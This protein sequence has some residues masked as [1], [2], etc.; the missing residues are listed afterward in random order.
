VEALQPLAR[1][2][3]A[4]HTGTDAAAFL[5]SAPRARRC[6]TYSRPSKVSAQPRSHTTQEHV[7]A[8]SQTSP[9]EKANALLTNCR[10]S[11][12]AISPAAQPQQVLNTTQGADL[13]QSA[14]HET[15]GTQ[16]P[17]EK[18][19]QATHCERHLQPTKLTT[20]LVP[21]RGVAGGT[22]AC[23]FAGRGPFRGFPEDCA[24]RHWF[25]KAAAPWR[26]RTMRR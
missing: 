14:H 19:D 23:R 5:R 7:T 10:G 2:S 12:P 16:L 26:I 25:C 6:R 11:W 17:P 15:Q 1:L 18:S 3:P 8:T 13:P 24:L 22:K 20:S 21:T 9:N 4:G